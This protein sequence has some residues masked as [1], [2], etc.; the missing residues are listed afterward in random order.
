MEGRRSLSDATK[1]DRRI[2]GGSILNYIDHPKTA[3]S[4]EWA[5]FMSRIYGIGLMY[6]TWNSGSLEWVT[7]FF[8]KITE[9]MKQRG[10]NLQ[11]LQEEYFVKIITGLEPLSAFD[12]F[13]SRWLNEGGRT[14]IEEIERETQQ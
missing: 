11:T 13:V 10:G 6:E 4:G 3:E 9:T 12:T 5:Y 1:V 2:I 7:P 8:P 14:I